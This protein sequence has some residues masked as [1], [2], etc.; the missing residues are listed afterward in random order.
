MKSDEPIKK[1]QDTR[2]L[3]AVSF[4]VIAVITAALHYPSLFHAPRSDHIAYLAETA[5]TDGSLKSLTLDSYAF[6]RTRE[7]QDIDHILFRPVLYLFMG[8]ERWLYG[9]DFLLWQLTSLVLHLCVVG[10]LLK[11][12]LNEGAHPIAPL[13]ALFFSVQYASADMV[14]W[15][16]LSGYL[17]FSVFLLGAIYH[18]RKYERRRSARSGFMLVLFLL[19]SAFTYELGCVAALFIAG[20]M[21]L[22]KKRTGYSLTLVLAA[23]AVPATYLAAS[24]LDLYVRFGGLQ[25]LGQVTGADHSGAATGMLAIALIWLGAG[26]VPGFV[27]MLPYE[28]VLMIP[29]MAADTAEGMIGI[30]AASVLL[31]SGIFAWRQAASQRTGERTGGAAALLALI[32][33]AQI[34]I[35]V[36]GRVGEKGFWRTVAWNSYYLYI[37]YLLG[38]IAIYMAIAP[39]RPRKTT[40]PVVGLALSLAVITALNAYSVRKLDI[41]LAEYSRP[42]LEFIASIE[43]LT[44]E[45]SGED[46]F[47]FSVS[48]DCRGLDFA[49][50]REDFRDSRLSLDPARGGNDRLT[51]LTRRAD[52]PGKTYTLA[53]ALYPRRYIEKGGRYIVSCK[54][55]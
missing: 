52:P 51:W 42:R 24:A 41:E 21:L 54:S 8:A 3:W 15:H 32:M 37:F 34:A 7:F 55:H 49:K 9:Y 33:L 39:A 22:G 23:L 48:A 29:Q 30:A 2:R 38:T 46:D 1:Y 53:E 12:L 13:F 35:V 44:A 19:L 4:L 26:L 31:V 14:V 36:L 25:A 45:H 27:S 28:R 20:Y 43:R 17:L 6:N 50:V 11:V 16:H 40:V 18:L 47:T 5:R 10:V